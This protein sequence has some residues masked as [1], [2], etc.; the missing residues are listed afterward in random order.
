L[1]VGGTGLLDPR[2]VA[3]GGMKGLFFRG[4][5]RRW[6]TRH[7]VATLRR[8]SR[9]WWSWAQSSSRIASGCSRRNWRT[10]AS[11]IGSQRG[12]RPPA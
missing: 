7:M 8:N 11:A 1:L 5:P 3:F 4:S 12:W 10:N 9:W 2:R 6:R